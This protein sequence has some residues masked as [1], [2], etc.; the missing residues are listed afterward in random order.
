MLR[1][2]AGLETVPAGYLTRFDLASNGA[3]DLAD[4]V[5]VARKAA[6]LE[7]NP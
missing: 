4:A 3:V 7:A 2:T 5:R 6:G 1:W